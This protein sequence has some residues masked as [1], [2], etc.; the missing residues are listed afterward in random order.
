MR[1]LL[2]LLLLGLMLASCDKNEAIDPLSNN[3]NLK[4][5][6]LN[7]SGNQTYTIQLKEFSEKYSGWNNYGAEGIS[8]NKSIIFNTT[9]PNGKDLKLK[10]WFNRNESEQ[11]LKLDENTT[12][13]VNGFPHKHWDYISYRDEIGNFYN[14]NSFRGIEINNG[15]VMGGNVPAITSN[16][17]VVFDV[18]KTEEVKANG[19][20]KT[21][22]TIKIKGEL[23]PYYSDWSSP[24]A[25]TYRVEGEFSGI[26][27]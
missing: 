24:E 21:R 10:I 15:N 3:L 18:V 6:E 16:K 5:T 7:S 11:L 25:A 17:N 26:I 22:V 12:G 19:E 1:N 9:L 2:C 4:I 8:I 13:F 14:N 20:S 23:H 27:E